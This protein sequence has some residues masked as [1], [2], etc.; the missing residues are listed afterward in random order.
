MTR[1]EIKSIFRCF[2]TVSLKQNEQKTVSCW[3]NRET[4]KHGTNNFIKKISNE[5][6][7]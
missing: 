5:I 6:S 7:R 4:I 2:V 3:S 1:F